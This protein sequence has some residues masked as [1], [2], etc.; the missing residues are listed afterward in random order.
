[1]PASVLASAV[2]A[3]S[4]DEKTTEISPIQL[5]PAA[6]VINHPAF[7]TCVWDLEPT[8]D[9]IVQVAH[10][11]RCGPLRIHYQ[12]HGDGPI[13]VLLICGIAA[14]HTA[15]QRQTLYFGH[16]RADKYSVLV[17]DNRGAGDSDKPWWYST[18]EMATDL[19]DVM[20]HVGWTHRRQIHVVGL[21]LGGMIA[22]ELGLLIPERISTLNLI[23]TAARIESSFTDNM[24]DY[25]R[26]LKPKTLDQTLQA[27]ALAMFNND[28]LVQPDDCSIPQKGTPKVKFPP[29][30]KADGE[31]LMFE[32]NYQRYAAQEISKQRMPGYSDA[33]KWAILGHFI[34]CG[35]HSK[36]DA[37]LRQIAEKV[38]GERILVLHTK[39]DM[40]IPSRYGQRLID[41]MRP[42]MALMMGGS[43]HVPKLEKA[44]WF[45]ELLEKSF[46]KG[47]ELTRQGKV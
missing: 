43:G 6:E 24:V 3:V 47:E 18:S 37:Q 8:D 20:N 28:W 14:R 36:S 45:N 1:M 11:R 41:V 13:R 25:L 12:I 4:R 35:F 32:T 42:G 2:T 46:A 40:M 16:E 27:S 44:K 21:S 22:Q 5:T 38:G 29:T 9:N 34:A 30:E 15:W 10:G 7:P 39:D 19:V 26:V 23:H 31:Y 33:D 17:A